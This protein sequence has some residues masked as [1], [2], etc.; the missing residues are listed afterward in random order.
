LDQAVVQGVNAPQLEEGPG[1]YPGTPLPGEPGN[2]AI[3]GHRTTYAHPFFSL[4][5]VHPGD[6]I[7]VTT[8]Q[9]TFVYDAI[10]TVVVPPTDVAVL[11]ATTD[12]ELTLTTCNPRY[13]AS[14]RL[15][16]RARLVR[17]VLAGGAEPSASRQPTSR[18]ST[19]PAP[20]PRAAA[21]MFPAPSGAGSWLG[22]LAWGLAAAAV[23]FGASRLAARRPR[24]RGW[25]WAAGTLPFLA[26]LF[27]C[28]AALS[29]LL[30]AGL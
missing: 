9:G 15:V 12:P 2:A 21:R 18:V 25:W 29:P 28:F 10:G 22:A 24:H 27:L 20:S 30:P 1:H 5:E 17:S 19:A 11:D 3:A 7:D 6:E 16:L 13:S 26:A 14:S 23:A 8:P 4:D